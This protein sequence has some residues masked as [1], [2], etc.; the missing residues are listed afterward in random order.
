MYDKD[1]ILFI[2]KENNILS[3]IYTTIYFMI[4]YKLRIYLLYVKDGRRNGQP[5]RHSVV[6]SVSS[7]FLTPI[8]AGDPLGS[9]YASLPRGVRSSLRS[10]LTPP[11]GMVR[12]EGG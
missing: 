7:S 10:S 12:R 2:G 6:S 8:P 4:G 1:R 9:A 5:T 11:A 3:L